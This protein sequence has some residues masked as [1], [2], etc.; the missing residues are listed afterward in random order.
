MM[1]ALVASALAVLVAFLFRKPAPAAPPEVGAA[2]VVPSV[3][4]TAPIALSVPNV[5]PSVSASAVVS[6]ST[7]LPSTARPIR[8]GPTKAVP[9][10]FKDPWK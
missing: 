8:T 2:L 9:G 6:A 10:E 3:T 1:A 7:Q 4:E 5:V